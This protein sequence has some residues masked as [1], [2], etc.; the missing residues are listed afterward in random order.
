MLELNISDHQVENAANFAIESL[1]KLI[2]NH[3]QCKEIS[4]NSIESAYESKKDF[5]STGRN[6]HDITLK[7][8]TNPGQHPE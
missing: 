1:N 8:I 5:N 3:E 6:F 2:I 4:L 7:M